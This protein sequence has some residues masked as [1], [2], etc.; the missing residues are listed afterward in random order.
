[1]EVQAKDVLGNFDIIMNIPK[2]SRNDVTEINK[3]IELHWLLKQLV[4]LSQY[5]SQE[6]YESLK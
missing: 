6:V 2:V 3:N 1:V 5:D 4:M